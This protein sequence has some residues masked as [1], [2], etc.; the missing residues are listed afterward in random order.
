[1]STYVKLEH[2]KH[3]NM[4]KFT[5]NFGTQSVEE[6]N[7]ILIDAIENGIVCVH[8]SERGPSGG[9][10]EYSFQGAP[11]KLKQWLLKWEFL[12]DEEEFEEMHTAVGD[13]EF[14]NN[15]LKSAYD[16]IAS[17]ASDFLNKMQELVDNDGLED[18]EFTEEQ[19][20]AIES[21]CQ[22]L[23]D[24]FEGDISWAS[25]VYLPQSKEILRY[26]NGDTGLNFTQF[27]LDEINDFEE[28]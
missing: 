3:I 1:M 4:V 18:R 11:E 13:H 5:A 14:V 2:Y 27:E 10:P 25:W 26:V 15:S 9:F 8:L 23:D 16:D 24:S 12:V 28:E 21:H 19:Q 17:G 6:R 22:M 20:D 7:E